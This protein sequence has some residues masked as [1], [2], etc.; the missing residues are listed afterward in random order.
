[1]TYQ[2]IRLR[3]VNECFILNNID[4]AGILSEDRAEALTLRN[5]LPHWILFYNVAA[6]DYFPEELI[7]GQVE[8]IRNIAVRNSVTPVS[9]LS[10]VDAR[11]SLKLVQQPCGR[12]TE[13]P[14]KSGFRDT[15][16]LAEFD[17]ISAC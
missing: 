15:F 11:S 4:L 3:L 6:Y 13:V 8:D 5:R 7:K 16:C 14:P 1:M 2:L 17:D 9:S 12:C 10:G